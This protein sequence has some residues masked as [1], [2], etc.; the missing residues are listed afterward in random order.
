ME[1]TNLLLVAVLFLILVTVMFVAHTV[2]FLKSYTQGFSSTREKVTDFK[3]EEK[4][5]DFDRLAH[6]DNSIDKLEKDKFR[7]LK[8]G[9]A[10]RRFTTTVPNAS[11]RT[12]PSHPNGDLYIFH[13]DVGKGSLKCIT[14][15]DISIV[16][17]YS[18]SKLHP[19]GIMTRGSESWE[20]HYEDSFHLITQ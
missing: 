18:S 3:G 10:L 1:N 14:K 9:D 2:Y 12:L 20:C 6:L 11:K 5:I 19:S 4:I 7:L 15:D 13:N 16:I 8:K 17:D